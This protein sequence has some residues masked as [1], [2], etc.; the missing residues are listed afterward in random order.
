MDKSPT[1]SFE[2]WSWV[3]SLYFAEAIPYMMVNVISVIM[4]KNLGLNN[5]DIALYTSWLYL[6]WVIKPLWSPIIDIFKTK[7][8]WILITQLFI[9]AGLAGVALTLPVDNYFRFTLAFFWLI[10]FGSATHDI[11]ADGFYMIGLSE[12][13]QAFFVG[14]RS[15]FYRVGMWFCQGLL[16]MF[17]GYLAEFE[18]MKFAWSVAMGI[19]AVMFVLFVFYHRW[20]LPAEEHPVDENRKVINEFFKTFVSFF[21]KNE[22]LLIL[23]FILFYRFGE[24]QLVK[25]ASPFLMDSKDVGGL[26]LDNI[27]LGF[28][29]GTV[30]LFSL[31]FGG[32]LGG[33]LAS[34]N[35]LKHW[36]WWM[37]I[38]IN[39]PNV[40][41]VY[42]SFLQPESLWIISSCVAVEQFGYGFG[43]TAYVLFMIYVSNGEHKTSHY[44]ICTGLMALG[45]MLPGMISGWMQEMLGYQMFFVWVMIATI[46]IFLITKYVSIDP[47]FGKKTS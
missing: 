32:I 45:M 13:R 7:R 34:R 16:V 2:G 42:M 35:G 10:A 11:A 24:G 40:V 33:V 17:V 4:Y 31:V 27:D 12:N 3:P 43:F 39:L 41:Y 28:V 8:Q 46:P 20:I 21:K 44:A 19:V 30:G 22:I 37:L 6:P 18:N 15:T 26:A 5:T 14:I 1:K 9:G 47:E 29:Y 25:L 36:I 38:A 23:A